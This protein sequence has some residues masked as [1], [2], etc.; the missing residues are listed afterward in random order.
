MLTS[1][2]IVVELPYAPRPLQIVLHQLLDRHRFG[3]AVCHRRF[4]KTV[5]AV[6]HLI[7][8]AMLCTKVRPRFAY[9]S[10][11]YRQGKQTAFDYMQYFSRPIPGVSFN[12]SELRVD[13]PNGGQVRIYGADNPDSL[14]G[15]Y[16][17]GIV[18]DEYGLMPSQVF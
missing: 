7:K 1:P 4:G 15:L 13:Y 16:L 11:T 18:L 8:A 5:L 10:P 3:V 17:D 12:Q 2:T 9:L 14:R 6:N